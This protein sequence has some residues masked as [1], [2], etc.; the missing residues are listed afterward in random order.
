LDGK[1]G[2]VKSRRK[3]KGRIIK[4]SIEIPENI[5]NL[6]DI[7]NSSKKAMIIS[8]IELALKIKRILEEHGALYYKIEDNKF[9]EVVL[10][11]FCVLD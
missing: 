10:K 11:C 9:R 8:S 5:Y 2:I 7:N 6:L 3:S 4:Y 1:E